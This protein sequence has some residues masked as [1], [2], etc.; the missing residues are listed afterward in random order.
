MRI[1]GRNSQHIELHAMK[2]LS[3]PGKQTIS[4]LRQDPQLTSGVKNS[5][6]GNLESTARQEAAWQQEVLELKD[7]LKQAIAF[8]EDQ[9]KKRK[10]AEQ[11]CIML[12]K[13]LK[14]ANTKLNDLEDRILA[15][16]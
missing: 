5:I 16:D 8:G 10:K 11:N 3:E 14:V 4:T 2:V 15:K 1:G 12:T 7:Q 6:S 13:D 9:A